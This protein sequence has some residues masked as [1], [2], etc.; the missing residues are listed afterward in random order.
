MVGTGYM[1]ISFLIW[2]K[3]SQKKMWAE[4]G[5]TGKTRASNSLIH[6]GHQRHAGALGWC[7]FRSKRWWPECSL[8]AR[9]LAV[10]LLFTFLFL[11][12]AW[13]FSFFIQILFLFIFC[14]EKNSS[15]C[16]SSQFWRKSIEFQNT[17]FQIFFFFFKKVSAWKYLCMGKKEVLR[18]IFSLSLPSV[19]IKIIIDNRQCYY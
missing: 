9:K 17:I 14:N 10:C 3:A 15:F 11:N 8:E 1:T 12:S 16:F 4:W 7:P 2:S 13:S 19:R 6:S 18:P 5:G